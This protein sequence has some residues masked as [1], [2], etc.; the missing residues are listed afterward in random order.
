MFLLLPCTTLK[1]TV[2]VIAL[3]TLLDY[4]QCKYTR[5]AIASQE[6]VAYC[7]SIEIMS[8]FPKSTA[9]NSNNFC[10]IYTGALKYQILLLEKKTPY[11][12]Q[13]KKKTQKQPPN[14]T[15]K[16][17]FVKVCLQVH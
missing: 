12:S 9:K 14:K 13:K 7:R 1:H 6:E 10:F 16:T 8:L 3:I 2:T 5:K 17:Y 15:V 4:I 11:P